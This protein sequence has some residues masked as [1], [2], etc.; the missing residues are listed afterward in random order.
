[1]EPTFGGD[2]GRGKSTNKRDGKLGF[3]M[4]GFD[5]RDLGEDREKCRKIRVSLR[6]EHGFSVNLQQAGD[7]L[8]CWESLACS[9]M[10]SELK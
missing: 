2:V 9:Q 10:S 5:E 8:C 3:V 4:A 6:E 1:M 7:K